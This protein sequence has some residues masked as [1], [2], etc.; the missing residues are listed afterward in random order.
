MERRQLIIGIWA[1]G[2][3]SMINKIDER[4]LSVNDDFWSKIRNSFPKKSEYINLLN[5][6]G[7]A[8]PTATLGLIS[9]YQEITAGG[10]EYKTQALNALKE[11]GSS[12]SLRELMANTFG[13]SP[14]EIALTRNA[15]EGL[16]I[17]LLGIDLKKNDEI[18]TTNADYDS[19]IKIIQQREKR[20]DIRLKLIDIP[21]SAV[22]DDEV[23]SAFENACTSNTKVILMCHMFNK[24]GQILPVR[25]ISE[26]ARK[27]GI[28]TIV[29]GAQSI[30]QIDFKI[31]ELGCDI[32]AASLHKWFWAPKGTGVLY[33]KKDVIEKVWPIWASWSGKPANSIEKFEEFGTVS[34][35]VSASLP[36]VFDFNQNIGIKKKE[37]RLRYLRDLWLNEI[38]KSDR[39][40]LLTNPNK[41]CAISA[42]KIKG[43]DPAKFANELRE[44]HNILIGPINLQYKPDF[45]GNYLAADLTNSEEEIYRFIHAFKAYIKLR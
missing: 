32:F 30:G 20:D 40:Q 1:T 38:I 22:E 29:D 15:M 5:T 42:F 18:L 4:N 27:K 13:C 26:M 45:K 43:V 28:R 10:G 16:G 33:V 44:K 25:E 37:N 39:I 3:L 24:N 14:S 8:V 2:A 35:A 11:S 36:S 17:G 12:Q 31:S 21:M 23:V 41:S 6:G 34:K 7:G 9:E 19:C